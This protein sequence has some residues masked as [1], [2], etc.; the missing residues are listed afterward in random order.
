M[1]N[2]VFANEEGLMSIAYKYCLVLGAA[3]FLAS[4]IHAAPAL[5]QTSSATHTC[6][7]DRGSC[8]YNTRYNSPGSKVEYIETMVCGKPDSVIKDY[9]CTTTNMMSGTHKCSAVPYPSPPTYATKI[10]CT[11]NPGHG[12]IEAMSLWIECEKDPQKK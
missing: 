12:A 1:A 5:A 6:N 11:C 10:T 9:S 3:V 4:F 8:V 2:R 7:I